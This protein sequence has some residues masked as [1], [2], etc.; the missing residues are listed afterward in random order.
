MALLEVKDL[1][2][3]FE[4]KHNS[5]DVL[6][7]INFSL[8]EGE[9][10]GIAGESGSGKTITALSI[11]RL[12]PSAARVCGGEIVYRGRN[13]ME[14]SRREMTKVRGSQIAMIFQDPDLNPIM[15]VESQLKEVLF[16]KRKDARIEELLEKVGIPAP[17]LRMKA[18]PFTMS[19]GMKQR[20]MIAMMALARS[21]GL[22]IADEPT[23]ALDVT[24]QAQILD[25]LE[26]TARENNMGMIFITHNLALL[27]EHADRIIV[28]REG[29][30]VEH[31][32]TGEF[33]RNPRH[34]YSKNLLQAVPRIDEYRREVSPLKEG[35]R[36]VFT[37]DD[38]FVHFPVF[39][40]SGILKKRIGNVRAV[41]GVDFTVK[42]GE[43]LGIVGESGCGKTTFARA[44]LR[45]I[46]R[47]DMEQAGSIA[48]LRGNEL[49][50]IYSL[51][52]DDLGKLR[53]SVQI[54]FQEAQGALNP[55]RSVGDSVVEGLH[56][57]GRIGALERDEKA[58]ELLELVGVD[59]ES[60]DRF[61]DQFSSGQR[62]RIMI[63]RA[64]ALEPKILILD[65]PVS[66]LDVSIQKEIVDLLLDLKE[67]LGLTYIVISHDLALVKDIAHRIAVM[68]L[69]KIVESGPARE[70]I[71]NPLH[72]YTKALISAVPIPDPEKARRKERIILRGEIPSPADIPS[73]CRFRTRCPFATEFCA[74]E[75]PEF[76]EHEPEHL[77]ACHYVKEIKEGSHTA[78]PIS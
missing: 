45:L 63:A 18:H 61:P 17:R 14:F 42:Q 40:G 20:V 54:V 13:L 43:I 23:T 65:E 15:D 76:A 31:G 75:V 35:A 44:A 30:I 74:E 36:D 2:V 69:G 27:A 46:S 39:R 41:D 66:S 60:I 5:V 7:G 3:R 49:V 50:D 72:P 29:E 33:F 51:S 55:R 73:G 52:P 1:R 19:G 47:G 6:R 67:R 77:A 24:V 56:I 28:M 25:L 59:P 62:Q 58:K 48:F 32:H 9:I 11:M 78:P 57:H 64:L 22:L 34:S 12:L 71:E 37:S 21:P 10:V 53:E 68:Y 16:G 26:R 8:D 38:L 4:S 70:I